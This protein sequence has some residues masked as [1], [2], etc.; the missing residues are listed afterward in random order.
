MRLP[1]MHC[2]LARHTAPLRTQLNTTEIEHTMKVKAKA[3]YFTGWY[4]LFEKLLVTEYIYNIIEILI[5]TGL[6]FYG[7]LIVALFAFLFSPYG[8][9]ILYCI[10]TP[11]MC[12]RKA[13]HWRA[14]PRGIAQQTLFQAILHAAHYAMYVVWFFLFLPFHDQVVL[15]ALCRYSPLVKCSLSFIVPIR[16]RSGQLWKRSKDFRVDI[17][18]ACYLPFV[19]F[20]ALI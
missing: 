12:I 4:C 17:I 7:L 13:Y 20:T 15:H 14:A 8:R 16:C 3:T 9:I 10:Y 5:F 19:F 18:S 6:H 2:I 1:H 11:Y